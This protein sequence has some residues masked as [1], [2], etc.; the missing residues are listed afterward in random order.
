MS[1]SHCQAES[2][3][4]TA[5]FPEALRGTYALILSSSLDQIIPIGRRGQ[6]HVR[7]GFYIY[8]GSAFGAGGVRARVAHHSRLSRRPHW[9]ID[10]LRQ[11]AQLREIWW[12]HD[13]IRREHQWASVIQRL[14]GAS[15][16]LAGFGASDC[17][18]DTHLYFFSTQP[19]LSVFR[20]NLK[21]EFSLHETVRLQ[22]H[23]HG[24]AD[25]FP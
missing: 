25:S 4:T 12:T 3:V 7:P 14:C 20:R 1:R 10:Y 24:I 9:H 2:S 23:P 11:V 19:S 17:S 15:I 21:R 5:P 18:C 16:P 13:P 8:V 6:L 22:R